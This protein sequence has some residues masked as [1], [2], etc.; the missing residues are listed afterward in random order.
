MQVF[1]ELVLIENL[2]IDYLLLKATFVLNR[3]HAKKGRL[4][5]SAFLGALLALIYPLTTKVL[6]LNVIIKLLSGIVVVG[7]SHKF[8][9]K[10]QF[11]QCFLTFVVVTIC[12]GG[13]IV[14]LYDLTGRF[15]GDF[16]GVLTVIP[17]GV[18]INICASVIRFLV[19]KQEKE[20]EYK[21]CKLAFSK[22]EID[23]VGF[24]DTG[25]FLTVDGYPAVV[26]SRRTALK[27]LG[28]EEYRKAKKVLVKT[29][30]GEN[31]LTA[32]K[33]LRLEIYDGD[34]PNIYNN[35]WVIVS[36]VAV[37]SGFDLILHP[38]LK[39]EGEDNGI[40]TI[41]KVG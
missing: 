18:A 28:I 12:A 11:Y 25:N 39:K 23:C 34:E 41:K 22:R 16:A 20:R 7:V 17:V 4:F 40:S 9:S 21:C 15:G 29:A 32:V 26:L 31:C 30:T 37:G 19:R 3:L 13:A 6:P 33:S 36:S 24:Y 14:A 1:V 35:V 5:L 38:S 8:T 10:K 2:I 27:A